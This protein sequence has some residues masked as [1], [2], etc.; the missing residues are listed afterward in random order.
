ME[1]SHVPLAQT[2]ELTGI[3]NRWKFDQPPGDVTDPDDLERWRRFRDSYHRAQSLEAPDR[4]PLQVDVELTSQCNLRCAFCIHGQAKQEYRALTFDSFTRIVDEGERYGLVS[5]KFNYINEPLLVHDLPDYIAY[6]KAHRVLN[7][8]FAT[9]GVLL[10]A[11]NRERLIEART[12][13]VMIS[14]DAA[15]AETYET[16]RRSKHYNL[17]VQN[18]LSLIELRAKLGVSWPLVRVNFLK[19]ELNVH[20]AET[21]IRYWDGIADAIGFQD[22][23]ALPGVAGDILRDGPLVDHSE[24]RCSFPFKQLVVDSAGHILP[25]C[26]FSGREMPLGHI[27]DMSLAEAWSSRQM[28]AL[29]ALHLRGEW[30]DNPVCRHCVLGD[31]P[32]DSPELIQLGAK[33]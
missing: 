10:N 5:M 17:V 13:K 30:R 14:I 26:T 3:L 15:S 18:I 21:F 23:V 2:N 31:A 32:A 28:V 1:E 7:V 22:Q 33:A 29:Q 16:M 9:N 19:T 25:C 11:K 12:S 27:D 8:Y 4:F 20:E 6:A 24:F